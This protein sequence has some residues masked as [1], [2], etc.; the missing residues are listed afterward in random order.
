VGKFIGLKNPIGFLGSLRRAFREERT[1]VAL[2][3][4]DG[5]LRLECQELVSRDRLPVKFTGFLNQ[6]KLVNA[7]VAADV[8]VLP[9]ERET[10]GIVVNEA[11][12]SGL[13]C[14]V[15]DQ[16]GCGP[17]LVAGQGTGDVFPLHDEAALAF[18]MV[19]LARDPERRR[20]C[21]RRARALMQSYSIAT[22]VEGT[23]NAV[24]AVKR[25][26]RA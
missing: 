24:A 19:R 15:S 6:S 20:A 21:R 10:W 16:V 26:S 3:V 18:A 12:L 2:M 17:D 11:M 25:E 22:A 7:F 13:P 1:I 9:S 5:P 23:V 14:I 4:G 8:L